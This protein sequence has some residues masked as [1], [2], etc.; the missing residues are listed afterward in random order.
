MEYYIG[1]GG[2]GYSFVQAVVNY[3]D[4]IGKVL[5]RCVRYI[6]RIRFRLSSHGFN[7]VG[8][9]FFAQFYSG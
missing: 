9:M 5:S 8:P 7:I 1:G 2:G 4:A 3:L 6:S